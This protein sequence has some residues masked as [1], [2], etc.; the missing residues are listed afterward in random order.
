MSTAIA[1]ERVP[2]SF[3]LTQNRDEQPPVEPV[4]PFE[5]WRRVD[6]RDE[7]PWMPV[8]VTAVL[9]RTVAFY[10]DGGKYDTGAIRHD[11]C[12]VDPQAIQWRTRTATYDGRRINVDQAHLPSARFRTYRSELP[13][14]D[15]QRASSDRRALADQASKEKP[16]PTGTLNPDTAAAPKTC[17]VCHVTKPRDS[18]PPTGVN[19]KRCYEC[20]AA[21]AA[22]P[23]LKI[24]KLPKPKKAA[25]K[26]VTT[27]VASVPIP[28]ES[29]NG[30]GDESDVLVGQVKQLIAERNAL[31]SQLD[32]IEAALVHA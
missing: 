16:V 5:A 11:Q 17:K 31:R 9:E 28:P 12:F 14:P 18:F 24:K 27:S 6:D 32:A 8:T 22:V 4:V 25:V 10:G 2:L 15:E 1:T 20:G 30:F 21:E 19:A 26:V 3:L 23:D 29:K 7:W 13:S